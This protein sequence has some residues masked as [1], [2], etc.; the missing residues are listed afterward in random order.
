[1]KAEGVILEREQIPAERYNPGDRV[2][3]YLLEVKK[4][5]K[6]PQIV[7]SRTHPGLLARLFETE[8]P[9]IAAGIVQVKAAARE[10]GERAKV[11]VSSTKRDVDPIGACWGL[12]GTPIQAISR[13][14]W[15]EKIA[16]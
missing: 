9:E 1:G 5:A 10:P 6:G 14:L 15:G 4:T 11:A 2:R 12:R 3:A 16:H 7:L 8:L 13:A